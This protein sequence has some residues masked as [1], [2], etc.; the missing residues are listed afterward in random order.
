MAPAKQRRPA[1]EPV[2]FSFPV[3]WPVAATVTVT[4]EPDGRNV[5]LTYVV[6]GASKVNSTVSL[7]PITYG[8][9]MAVV[10]ATARAQARSAQARLAT[11]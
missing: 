11:P 3:S 2:T 8:I 5:R 4:V 10:A 7:D 6:D 9:V 1:T